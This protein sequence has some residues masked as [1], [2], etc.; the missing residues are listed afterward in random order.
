MASEDGEQHPG[1]E[2]PRAPAAA[3]RRLAGLGE[4]WSSGGVIG[5]TQSPLPASQRAVPRASSG[6]MHRAA[7]LRESQR[8][9]G[10]PPRDQ[11]YSLSSKTQRGVGGHLGGED[12]EITAAEPLI[13]REPPVNR[14]CRV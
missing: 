3:D 13:R 14:R 7:R 5:T 9:I 1:R 4:R 6:G 12:G 2:P 10:P 11:S 8:F